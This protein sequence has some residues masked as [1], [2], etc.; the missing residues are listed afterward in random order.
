MKSETTKHAARWMSGAMGGTLESD[1]V[2]VM[3]L[4]L[5]YHFYHGEG[6]IPLPGSL[7][8]LPEMTNRFRAEFQTV[9][10]QVAEQRERER[11]AARRDP[12]TQLARHLTRN[13]SF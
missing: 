2:T 5:A 11:E 10:Q 6:N 1:W 13:Y 3:L 12:A 9:S 7:R 4:H 8:G